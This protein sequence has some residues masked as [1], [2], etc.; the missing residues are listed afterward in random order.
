MDQNPEE[1]LQFLEERCIELE[2]HN[3]ALRTAIVTICNTVRIQSACLNGSIEAV[4]HEIQR[5]EEEDDGGGGGNSGS[6]HLKHIVQGR[7]Q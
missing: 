4:L 6:G 2:T 1:Y 5:K 3:N 7:I